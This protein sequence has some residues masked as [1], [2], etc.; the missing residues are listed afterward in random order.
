[1][2]KARTSWSSTSGRPQR[3]SSH[4]GSFPL[5]W[6]SVGDWPPPSVLSTVT[7]RGPEIQ[8]PA[9]AV[10]SIPSDFVADSPNKSLL[11]LRYDLC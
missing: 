8:P 7:T 11:L 1:M 2:A 4:I 3:F 6:L 10:I 5:Q 9:P